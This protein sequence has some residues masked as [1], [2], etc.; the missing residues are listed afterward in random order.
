METMD[1][2]N[3]VLL[4]FL[5]ASTMF[6]VASEFAIV[7]VRATRIDQLV[8]EGNRKAMAAKRVVTHLD[9]YLSA[10]QL[11]ITIT[12][13]GIGWLGEPTVKHLI[14]PLFEKL[15]IQDSVASI[16]SFVIAFSIITFLHVVVGEL[17]PKSVAI[18]KAETITMNFARPLIMFYR[19]MFPIIWALNHSARFIT[20]LFGIKPAGEG[21]IA[22]SEEE[23]RMILT[24]SYK[25]GEINQS[26]FKYVNNIFEFDDRIAREIMVPRTEIQTFQKDDILEDIVASLNNE[27][28]TRYPVTDGDKDT[29]I[30]FVNVK[31]LLTASLRSGL[32]TD[33]PIRDYVKPLITVIETIPIHDLLVKMQKE[34]IHIAVLLDEYGGT[35]GIVTVE[36]ILEEIVGEIRDEFDTDELPEIR[37]I[38]DS[39]YILDAKMLL[40]EIEDLLGIHMDY[41]DVD[42]LGGW[43][44]THKIDAAIGDTLEEDGFIFTVEDA[45]DHHLLYIEVKKTSELIKEHTH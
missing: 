21:D 31:E 44:L 7:K 39:H 27:Q 30:G 3:I 2:V 1:I 23:L 34:R 19:V 43:F 35:S 41:P 33:M 24:D 25:K 40:S 20:S 29:I 10:T 16:I 36:D 14:D 15:H 32:K 22:H 5:L 45:E 42:T 6:F 28:Y 17:A 38:G 4:L 8:A 12:S 11:G 37:R 26:E 18:Q 13:L 9:E